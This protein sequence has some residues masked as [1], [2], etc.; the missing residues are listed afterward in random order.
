MILRMS[1]KF[2]LPWL[3]IV[4]LVPTI[5]DIILTAQQRT[6]MQELVRHH[7]NDFLAI[8]FVDPA[9][10]GY[11]TTT[12]ETLKNEGNIMMM[13]SSSDAIVDKST[14]KN[15]N[16]DII[17]YELCFLTSVFADDI[18]SADTVANVT[19]HRQS[20][21]TFQ[22]LFFT[23]RRDDLSA[24]GWK[25]IIPKLHYKRT[26]T[27]S[28][29]AKFVPWQ[30]EETKRMCPVIFYMDGYTIPINT[31]EASEN[32]R[33]AAEL[34]R[35]HPFGLGQY[36]KRGSRIHKLAEGL[37]EKGKDTAD[38]VNYTMSWLQKQP[39][40]R[41]SCTVYL[42]RHL[43]IDPQNLNYQ[44][45]SLYFWE[46]YSQELGSWRDQLLWCYVVDKFQAHPINL[47]HEVSPMKDLFQE[48][49]ENMG[50]NGHKYV[51]AK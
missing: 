7:A 24:P 14:N 44:R 19:E 1:K 43:G 46:L 16:N 10:E 25:K 9:K 37:V 20:N 13:N 18:A 34:I 21:P 27:Q 33:R 3:L 8:P 35:T 38:N 12:T 2:V 23:N 22:Y 28:R 6:V 36:P 48:R 5:I 4:V 11:H 50:Y 47:Y 40:F 49:R 30:H 39:D 26:I 31:P 32:F 15:N 29:W 45:L 51:D 17:N 41:R 42:N